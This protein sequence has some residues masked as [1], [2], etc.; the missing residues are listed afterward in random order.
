MADTLLIGATDLASILVLEDLSEI[1]AKPPTNQNPIAIPGRA[2][3]LFTAGVP[4]AYDM[5]LPVTIER[6]T[7]VEMR[8]AVTAF[9]ALLDSTSTP[10]TLV[11]R[12]DIIVGDEP[13]VLDESCSA[14][15]RDAWEVS[16]LGDLA[17]RIVVTLR[18]L[19]GGWAAVTP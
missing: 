9:V 17:T 14:I 15:C 12:S 3:E 7:H 8:A 1:F 2:G 10:L 16:G 6:D 13:A 11:R 19:D 4:S 5:L 18:N